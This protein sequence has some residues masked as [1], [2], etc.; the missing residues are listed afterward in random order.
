M[1]FVSGGELLLAESEGDFTMTEWDEAY[2]AACKICAR[3]ATA[4]TGS[5]MA[6]DD[7]GLG[8]VDGPDMDHFLRSTVES[9][10]AAD[11]H[12]T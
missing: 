5:A 2:E 11:L 6:L 3:P 9:K 4:A 1:A 12:W 7:D 8:G 10:V